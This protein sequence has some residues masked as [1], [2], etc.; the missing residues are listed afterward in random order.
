MGE[1]Q[2]EDE[3][4]GGGERGGE[5]EGLAAEVKVAAKTRTCVPHSTVTMFR[6]ANAAGKPMPFAMTSAAMPSAAAPSFI[7]SSTA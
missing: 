6:S 5:R 1:H 3:G 4:A 2:G 7:A